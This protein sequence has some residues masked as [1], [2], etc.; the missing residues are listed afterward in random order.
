MSTLIRNFKR[1]PTLSPF[2]RSHKLLTNFNGEVSGM[3]A[4]EVFDHALNNKCNV[5]CFIPGFIRFFRHVVL[6]LRKSISGYPGEL[7]SGCPGMLQDMD[8]NR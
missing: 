7:S 2:S 8:N 4:F 1:V 6:G 3:V 5:R